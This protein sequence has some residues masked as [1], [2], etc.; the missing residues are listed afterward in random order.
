ME[1]DNQF[2]VLSSRKIISYQYSPVEI[3]GIVDRVEFCV[4]PHLSKK[5]EGFSRGIYLQGSK[6]FIVQFILVYIQW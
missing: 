1:E 4:V 2:S 3:V 6:M 5:E